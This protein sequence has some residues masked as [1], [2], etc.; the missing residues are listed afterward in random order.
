MVV[1]GKHYPVALNMQLTGAG[2]HFDWLRLFGTLPG[3]AARFDTRIALS[4]SND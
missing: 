1:D 2:G 3:S 4:S